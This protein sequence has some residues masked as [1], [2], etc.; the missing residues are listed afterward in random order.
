MIIMIKK[1]FNF[2]NKI[3]NTPFIRHPI[4]I[5]LCLWCINIQMIYRIP[6]YF[7]FIPFVG[8]ALSALNLFLLLDSLLVLF[9][10][11]GQL[12]RAIQWIERGSSI[13]IRIFVYSTLLIYM[14]GKL[15]DKPIVEKKSQ[16]LSIS[17]S[18][19]K[20]GWQRWWI[21][22]GWAALRFWERPEKTEQVLLLPNETRRLWPGEHIS[23]FI[24]EGILGLPWIAKIA[25]D[26][27]SYYQG[28]LRIAPK[29]AIAWKGLIYYYLE[30]QKLD[31]AASL[32]KEYLS[33]YPD[34]TETQIYVGSEL[35]IAGHY[36]ES[37]EFFEYAISKKPEYEA[38][39]MMGWALSFKG[40]KERAIEAL[41]KAIEI[42]PNDY[43]G[44]YHSGYVYMDL[45]KYDNAEAMFIKVLEMQ[46]NFPEV[47]R[48]LESV[49]RG[50]K[51]IH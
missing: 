34:D 46:P 12:R 49:R 17:E 41:K 38:Y 8:Y 3:W 2:L 11:D 18:T 13:M 37:I 50:K 33:I 6:G 36:A 47:Q 23:V 30:A 40:D 51:I 24:R 27:E 10:E 28:I 1:A 32:G 21:Y 4:T 9:N 16:I 25:R 15:T 35:A 31:K 14:N 5:L 19:V 7:L 26:Q 22:Y 42:N 45:G 44:Y 43:R 48:L 39:R 29:A 20:T